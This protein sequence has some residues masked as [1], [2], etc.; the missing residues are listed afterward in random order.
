M[1][2]PTRVR[3]RTAAR[4]CSLPVSWSARFRASSN[5]RTSPRRHSSS[6]RSCERICLVWHV[7]LERLLQPGGHIEPHDASV[8]DAALREAREETELEL[9]F[10][11]AAPRPF[12]LDIHEIGHG[13]ASR[14]TSISTCAT[15]SSGAAALY[16]RRV[17]PARRAGGGVGRADGPKS[18][19]APK[20]G[21]ALS[22]SGLCGR[23]A[24]GSVALYPPGA[25]SFGA[26][27][28]KSDA[29]SWICAR[30]GPSSN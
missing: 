18:G 28:W 1:S 15:C 17:V 6:T 20:P 24:A 16:R 14:R 29:S 13:R 23:P 21:C 27:G 2:R 10:H 4:C 25:T 8:E 9:A 11:P 7:K 12:D 5:G 3:R 26:S 19:Q 30:P 22:S